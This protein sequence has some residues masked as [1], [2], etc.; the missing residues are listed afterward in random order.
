MIKD[1]AYQIG[2]DSLG[3]TLDTNLFA[4]TG[5]T[6]T[7]NTAVIV[8]EL[9]PGHSPSDPGM[10]DMWQ[11]PL[12]ILSRAPDYW[13]ARTNAHKVFEKWHGRLGLVFGTQY[14]DHKWAVN[15]DCTV[16]YYIGLDDKGRFQFV[17]TIL[18]HGEGIN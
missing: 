7:P 5:R 4:G 15:S 18:L 17:F 2:L 9:D 12:R 8:E 3:L 16:P 6:D 10:T 1:V 13:T 11:M 14:G